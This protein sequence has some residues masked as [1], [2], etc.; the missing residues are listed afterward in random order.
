MNP[1]LADT[2]IHSRSAAVDLID[3][4]GKLKA[5]ARKFK[6]RRGATAGLL[7]IT[8]PQATGAKGRDRFHALRGG[9]RAEFIL[10]KRGG[11]RERR[12]GGPIIRRA[13]DTNPQLRARRD[14]IVEDLATAV[15]EGIEDALKGKR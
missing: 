6:A 12:V 11:K 9:G 15:S 1:V 10:P 4:A 3:F 5:G 14:Q 2:S 13:L 7:A 8:Q